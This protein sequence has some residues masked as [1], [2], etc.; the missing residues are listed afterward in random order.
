MSPLTQ[1]RQ[2]NYNRWWCHISWR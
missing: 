2:H 1:S